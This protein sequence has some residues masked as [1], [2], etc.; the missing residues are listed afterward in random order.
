MR[1]ANAYSVLTMAVF[2]LTACSKQEESSVTPPS[3]PPLAASVDLKPETPS[4]PSVQAAPPP[5]APQA[6]LAPAPAPSAADP[7]E[8]KDID[9]KTISVLEYVESLASGYERTRASQTDGTPWPP[10]TNLDQLVTHRVV[11]RLPAAPPGQKFVYDPQ[12]GKVSLAAQ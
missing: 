5:V 2:S 11:S 9:G 3:P 6:A 8:F 7:K 1:F 12:T 4:A 10:L